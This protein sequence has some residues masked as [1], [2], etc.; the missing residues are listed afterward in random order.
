MIRWFKNLGW[1]LTH[2]WASCPKGLMSPLGVLFH[3]GEGFCAYCDA[4]TGPIDG[5]VVVRTAARDVA[6]R[7]RTGERDVTASTFTPLE[8][9]AQRMSDLWTDRAVA[10]GGSDRFEVVRARV[11]PDGFFQFPVSA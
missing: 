8:W 9:E 2:T 10:F 3:H 5:W 6:C 7:Q 4:C 11:S 1:T